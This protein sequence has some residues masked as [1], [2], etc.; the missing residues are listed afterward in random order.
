MWP[1]VIIG[2]VIVGYLFTRPKEAVT[3]AEL[4]TTQTPMGEFVHPVPGFDVTSGFGER[5]IFG[6]TSFHYG[7]AYGTPI[8]TPVYAA[9]DGTVYVAGDTGG[10]CGYMVGIGWDGGNG[11][12]GPHIEYCHLSVVLVARDEQVKAGQKIGLSGNTGT[13]TGPHLHVEYKAGESQEYEL[14]PWEYA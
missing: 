14:P 9:H 1:A 4:E 11:S 8:G 12:Q 2:A 6:S 13:S 5:F 10:G 3:V 7:V